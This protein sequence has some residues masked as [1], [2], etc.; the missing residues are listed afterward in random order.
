MF[1]CSVKSINLSF[2]TCSFR[3]WVPSCG[4]RLIKEG[5]NV[6]TKFGDLSPEQLLLLFNQFSS[7]PEYEESI[8]HVSLRKYY[9]RHSLPFDDDEN[10]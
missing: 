7:W 9:G 6:F 2:S 10:S 1:S 5:M 3:G 8:F 4:P